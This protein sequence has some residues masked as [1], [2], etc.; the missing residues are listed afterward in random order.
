MILS[1]IQYALIMGTLLGDG[2]LNKRGNSFRLKIEHSIKQKDYVHWKYNILKNLCTTTKGPYE[3]EN[4]GTTVLFYT[5]SG[6]YLEEIYH[7]FYKI[8]PSTGRYKKTITPELIE[9]LPLHPLVLTA[10]F[11]D[12]GDVRSDCYAGKLATQGLTKEECLL[13]CN[14]L[15]KWGIEAKVVTHVR[16]KNQ[17]YISLPAKNYAF[18]TL[19]EQIE[20]YVKTVPGMQYKLN[21]KKYRPRND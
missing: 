19:I 8:N 4:S 2:H 9:N 14:Y 7:F 16:T 12:D 18:G 21:R 5:S 17:Y 6:K 20:A 1:D 3:S 15:Q 13:L 10:W 11:L